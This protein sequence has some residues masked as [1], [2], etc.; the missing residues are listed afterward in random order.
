MRALATAI[1][2]AM[3]ACA[4]VAQNLDDKAR[5]LSPSATNGTATAPQAPIGHRQPTQKN[6]P[7]QIQKDET[8]GS[9]VH[10]PL[11]PLPQLCKGC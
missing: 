4:A 3:L 2:I 5:P 8:T 11:G 1:L 7:P 10:D 9:G 6:L